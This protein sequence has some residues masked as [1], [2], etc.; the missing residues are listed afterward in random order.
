MPDNYEHYK[1]FMS[2]KELQAFLEAPETLSL[3]DALIVAMT[4]PQPNGQLS[5]LSFTY[6]DAPYK[7]L[8]MLWLD[9][10]KRPEFRDL[11]RVHATEGPGKN[12]LTWTYINQGRLDCYFVLHVVMRTP[13]RTSFRIPIFV[14]EWSKILDTVSQTGAIS[15]LAGPPVK[16]RD[17]ITTLD[18]VALEETIYTQSGGGIT[19]TFDDEMKR[20]LRDHYEQHIKAIIHLLERG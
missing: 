13:V 10:S 15:L 2:N 9:I 1:A 19:L 3:Q 5:G 20:E 4:Q 11:A 17:L 18:P 7:P 6:P 8:T 14:R 12:T 16:W